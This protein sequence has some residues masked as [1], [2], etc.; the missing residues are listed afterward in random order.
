[1]S[2]TAAKLSRQVLGDLRR[3]T[4]LVV[5]AG[6]AGRLAAQALV[7]QGAGRLLV[8]TRR[9]ARAREIAEELRGAAF[10]FEELAAVLAE[11]DI[12]LTCTSAPEF[13][14]DAA[15]VAEAMSRRPDRPL[16][17]VD[18]AVP[19]D[20][21]PAA[22][23]VPGARVFDIDDLQMA[24]EANREARQAEVV[25]AE[26]IVEEEM[27]RFR[28]WFRNLR[29]MPTIA[30]MRRQAEVARIRELEATLAR[31]PGL[32]EDERQ[33]LDAMTR[34]IVKRILHTP[35]NRL[36]LDAGQ[37]HLDAARELFGLNPEDQA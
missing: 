26:A 35:M 16:V 28:A 13:V 2:A 30:S 27:L 11:V 32:S 8:T 5:G 6:E 34:A 17:M 10:P 33:R 29:V 25:K 21:D 36:R 18:I 3:K 14:I 22:R 4:V 19:R 7:Q 20:V 24:A 37:R 15:M 9:A 12:A 31:L 23:D 1:V